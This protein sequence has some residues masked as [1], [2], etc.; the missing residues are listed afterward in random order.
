MS[1]KGYEMKLTDE[2]LHWSTTIM[3]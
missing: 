3:K 2:R 1:N